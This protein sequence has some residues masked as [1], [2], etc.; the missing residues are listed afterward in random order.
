[1]SASPVA[2]PMNADARLLRNPYVALAPTEDGYF[3]YHTKRD[4]LHRLNA[5]AALIVE[6]CD[7]TRTTTEILADVAPFVADDAGAGSAQWIE[8]ALQ[9][10]LLKALTRGRSDPATPS[11]DYFSK[12][13]PRLRRK[14]AV[15]AAFVCQYHA[16]LQ[17]PDDPEQWCTLGDLAHIVGRRAD[18]REAYERYLELSPGGD[19]EV[20]HIL[21][22]LRGDPAPTRAPDKAIL[23]L[24]SRFAEFYERNMRTDLEYCGPEELGGALHRIFGSSAA[25]EVL[26]LGCGTGLAASQLRPLAR[27]LVGI[28]LSPD[29]IE[30]ARPTG[31]YDTLEVAEITEWLARSNGRDFDLI[32]ACDT[33]IYFGDLRQVLI[34]AARRLRAGG[35][36]AFTVERGEGTGFRLTDSGR[37][38]HSESHVHDVARDAQLVIES[39]DTPVLRYEYGK[40][41]NAL[42]VVM[43]AA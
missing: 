4:R 34:A 39:I 15:L 8:G 10:D 21:V 7:G 16:A 42:V 30:R 38:V 43:R 24:Y 40:P 3:A 2:F 12:L 13:A 33:F 1:V 41:V 19:A 9:D 17:M 25:L 28:D 27:R 18:A 29:M 5:A 32:A 35:V 14:G 36:I 20:E 11:P 22:S 31:S 37:Y 6:L 26:E 23:Q